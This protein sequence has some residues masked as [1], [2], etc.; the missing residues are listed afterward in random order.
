MKSLYKI[1]WYVIVSP[2][3]LFALGGIVGGIVY[4]KSEDDDERDFTKYVITFASGELIYL[5]LIL[6]LL[7]YFG[8]LP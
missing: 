2:F 4:I 8:K 5:F 1:L 6:Y 7:N 3:I